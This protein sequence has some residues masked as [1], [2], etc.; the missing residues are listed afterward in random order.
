MSRNIVLIDP[1][2]AQSASYRHCFNKI[3][4]ALSN[5]GGV[6]PIVGVLDPSVQ[7]EANRIVLQDRIVP[8]IESILGASIS[9]RMIRTVSQWMPSAPN[10]FVEVISDFTLAHAGLARRT[11]ALGI[12]SN[13]EFRGSNITVVEDP[14]LGQA[15]FSIH[16]EGNVCQV[17]F[18]SA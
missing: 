3:F 7:T 4:R 1:V 2:P 12:V 9:H 6:V 17:T 10:D 18:V 13:T 14:N 5:D 15:A 11:M 16:S 8:E